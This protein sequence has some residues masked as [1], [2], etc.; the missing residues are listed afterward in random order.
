MLDII[1]RRVSTALSIDACANYLTDAEN[2]QYVLMA[3]DGFHP[4]SIGEVRIDCQEGLLGLVA[5]R[6]GLMTIADAATH[7]HYVPALTDR[8]RKYISK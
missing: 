7:P 4:A 2:S 3:A 8:V 6:R 5:E 1:V